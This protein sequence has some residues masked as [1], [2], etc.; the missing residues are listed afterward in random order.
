MC[1]WEA[2]LIWKGKKAKHNTIS[3][4]AGDVSGE[5][6][7]TPDGRY[8]VRA[9]RRNDY[10]LLQGDIVETAVGFVFTKDYNRTRDLFKPSKEQQ[11]NK[12]ID[13]SNRNNYPEN[14]VA[15]L[16]IIHFYINPVGV[17]GLEVFAGR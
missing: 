10:D 14:E 11:E 6:K 7:L 5:Y 9:Y 15:S 3:N 12:K 4:I 16:Y 2:I 1:R 17:Y 8:R 13:T